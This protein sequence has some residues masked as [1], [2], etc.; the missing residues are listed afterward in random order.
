MATLSSKALPG[1][2]ATAAQ[3]TLAA[4]AVQPAD[5]AGFHPVAVTG[6][7]PSL[8]VGTY[9]FFDN[10]TLSGNTTVT[11]ASIPTEAKWSYSFTPSYLLNAI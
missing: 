4:S 1:G 11:F 3:G 9:N 7:S 2:I 10:G 5:V 6:T 8:N